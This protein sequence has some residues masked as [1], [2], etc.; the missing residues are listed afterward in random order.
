LRHQVINGV[1]WNYYCITIHFAFLQ[2]N[3]LGI[4]VNP[5][6]V[7]SANEIKTDAVRGTGE[8]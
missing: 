4:A 2:K 5:T 1:K 7:G 8:L 6:R 3:I